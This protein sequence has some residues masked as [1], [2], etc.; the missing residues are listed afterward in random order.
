LFGEVLEREIC[1][2]FSLGR[3]GRPRIVERID[4]G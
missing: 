1:F 4:R 2:I 3:F